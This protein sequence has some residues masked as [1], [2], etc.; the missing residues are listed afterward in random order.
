MHRSKRK[1]L[2][3]L[4]HG[5]N[6]T[7]CAI[8][9]NVLQGLCINGLRLYQADGKVES[10]AI[11]GVALP[12]KHQVGYLEPVPWAKSVNRYTYIFI[13]NSVKSTWQGG[14]RACD[15]RSLP[16]SKVIYAAIKNGFFYQ[17]R[18]ITNEIA[19]H[20]KK[21]AGRVNKR[22]TVICS[23]AQF[24]KLCSQFVNINLGFFRR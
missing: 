2:P 1:R 20:D 24:R 21:M 5:R 3:Q 17:C 16:D 7:A 9:N 8:R 19:C 12:D 14:L 22:L 10:E 18:A 15:V 11:E 4:Q 23:S 6:R 13:I